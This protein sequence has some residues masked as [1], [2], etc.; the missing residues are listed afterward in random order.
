MYFIEHPFLIFLFFTVP[1][2]GWLLY[3]VLSRKLNLFLLCLASVLLLPAFSGYTYIVENSYT[4]LFYLGLACCYSFLI[5]S[6][7]KPAFSI[8]TQSVV[9]IFVCGVISFY[10]SFFGAVQ[11]ENEWNVKNYK[12]QYLREQGFSGGPQMEYELYHYG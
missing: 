1:L 7:K 8:I 5:K 4:G 6:F 9:L 12:I 10:S 11:V 2:S 3:K